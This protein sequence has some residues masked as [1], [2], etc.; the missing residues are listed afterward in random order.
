MRSSD[1]RSDVCSSD[2]ERYKQATSSHAQRLCEQLRPVLE[3]TLASKLQG[4]Y[5]SGKRINMKRVIGYIA[6]GFRKDKIW[7]RRAQQIGQASCRERVCQ[8][9]YLSVVGVTLKKKK[10]EKQ[11]NE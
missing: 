9:V 10:K 2:L 1:W 6:S 3:P 11:V 7:M 8:D 5:R 4:D